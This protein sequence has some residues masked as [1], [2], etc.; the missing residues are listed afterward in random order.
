METGDTVVS[1]QITVSS[2]ILGFNGKDIHLTNK[3][4]L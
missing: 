1:K 4:T 2:W 3:D